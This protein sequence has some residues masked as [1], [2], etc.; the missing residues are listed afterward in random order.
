MFEH[1]ANALKEKLGRWG[2]FEMGATDACVSCHIFSSKDDA[3]KV[4]CILVQR[5]YYVMHLKVKS[6]SKCRKGSF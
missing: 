1:E 2:I 5:M 3:Q 6:G 4:Q